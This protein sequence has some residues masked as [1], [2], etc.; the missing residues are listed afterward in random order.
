ML[1]PHN[2]NPP[3]WVSSMD[4]HAASQLPGHNT[5]QAPELWGNISF[6]QQRVYNSAVCLKAKR[7]FDFPKY[8]PG[9]TP[10]G[11]LGRIL[12]SIKQLLH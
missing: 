10:K 7:P 9:P 3:Y 11:D 5:K 2:N 8:T 6:A 12:L 1:L 4:C